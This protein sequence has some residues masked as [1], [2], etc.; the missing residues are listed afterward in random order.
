MTLTAVQQQ[1]VERTI[2]RLR[3]STGYWISDIRAEEI[4]GQLIFDR[5]A[6]RQP[7]TQEQTE[8]FET[9]DRELTLWPVAG[10]ARRY[11]IEL[12]IETAM[13]LR[14]LIDNLRP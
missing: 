10:I 5:D 6:A 11:H 12:P 7:F 2:E 13:T 14:S 4:I 1:E 3:T 9:L 8:A